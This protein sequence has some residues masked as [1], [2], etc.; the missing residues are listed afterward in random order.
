MTINKANLTHKDQI[1]EYL[2]SVENDFTP[3]LF[4]RISN[5]STVSSVEEYIEKVINN[6]TLLYTVH[7]DQISGLVVIYHNDYS[8]YNAYIPLLSVKQEFSG[9]GIAKLLVNEAIKLA[10][11]SD[12]HEIKVKTWKENLAAQKVYQ[13]LGFEIIETI[14]DLTLIKKIK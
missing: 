1:Y 13:N 8:T 9:N 6:G 11:E 2:K 5:R 3:P 7:Q 4:N 14:N 10:T 12:M